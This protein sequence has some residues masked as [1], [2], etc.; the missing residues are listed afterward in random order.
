MQLATWNV[1]SLRYVCRRCWTGWQRGRWMLC[2]QEL[3]L[4]DKVF[5]ADAFSAIGY[6]STFHGAEDLQRCGDSVA[7]TGRRYP[8]QPAES[9]G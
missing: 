4:E 5:P 8:V 7:A 1:N 2:L 6:H 3:K 9:A